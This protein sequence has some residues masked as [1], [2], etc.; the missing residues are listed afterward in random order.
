MS[1][2]TSTDAPPEI[3]DIIVDFD[4][5]TGARRLVSKAEAMETFAR[6]GRRGAVQVVRRIPADADGYLDNA[7]VDALLIT[8][9][10]EI[11]RLSEEFMQARRVH[12]VLAPLLQAMRNEGIAPPYRVVDVGCGTGYLIRWLAAR[13]ALGEDVELIGTDYNSALVG[14]ARYLAE[15]EALPCRFEV[16]NAFHLDMPGAVYTSVGVVHHFRGS[17]LAAFFAAQSAARARAF[18]HFDIRASILAP[19]G[20]WIF[21]IARMKSRLAH[22]DGVL[23][24]V[25][26]HPSRVLLE[27]ARQG[28]PDY[29]VTL[30]D[31]DRSPLPIFK[32][33]HGLVGVETGLLGPLRAAMGTQARRLD[34]VEGAR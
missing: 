32:V 4:P 16:C 14:R 13:G 12:D 25:R 33:M 17:D 20:A 21:H 5:E 18:L 19:I 23:S 34:P 26:A 31:E 9:H 2:D 15:A 1:A 22:H 30:F 6:L 24:A 7:A 8:V 11:Q 28:A 3:S 27:A 29:A 10:A